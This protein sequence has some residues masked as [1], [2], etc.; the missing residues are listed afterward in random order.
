MIDANP[1][2]ANDALIKPYVKDGRI[3]LSGLTDQGALKAAS[4]LNNYFDSRAKGV[5]TDIAAKV[6]LGNNDSW[7]VSR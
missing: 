3:D 7:A 5:D 4:D 6:A 1:A 2:I